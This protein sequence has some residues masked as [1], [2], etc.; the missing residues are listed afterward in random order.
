MCCRD[1]ISWLAWEPLGISLKELEG[2]DSEKIYGRPYLISYYQ[3]LIPDKQRRKNECLQALVVCF[4]N[5]CNA[6]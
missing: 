3:D 4:I 6:G 2:K 1:S 5:Y